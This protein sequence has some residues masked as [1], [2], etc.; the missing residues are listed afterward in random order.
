MKIANFI[1]AVGIINQIF[2]L[3]LASRHTRTQIYKTLAGPILSYGSEAWTVRSN[4]ETRL[5]PAE[6]CFKRRAVGP[7]KKRRSYER[8][9]Q[10]TNNR[11][12]RKNR[13]NWKKAS[14]KDECT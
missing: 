2:K 14:W 13:R 6:I 7:Q 12:Y 8:I 1:K 11:I 3:S 10:S 4:D 9:T 5:V